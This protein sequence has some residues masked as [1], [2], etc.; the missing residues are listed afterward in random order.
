[1]EIKHPA[2][3]HAQRI[4]LLERTH[5]LVKAHPK[6]AYGELGKSWHNFLLLAVLNGTYKT[7]YNATF[8]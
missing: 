5:A 1:M 2:T 3:K 7:T 4:R 8:G 6:T